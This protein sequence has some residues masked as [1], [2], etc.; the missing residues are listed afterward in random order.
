MITVLKR[1]CIVDFQ[2]KRFS[3]Y[4]VVLD[5]VLMDAFDDL[6]NPP[7][8]VLSVVQNRWLSTGLKETAIATAVWSILKAKRRL[9]KV[10][11]N[12]STINFKFSFGR[13]DFTNR[14]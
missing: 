9:L 4:D 12:T 8:S 14:L 13:W 10:C 11:V 3:L 7:S 6:C 5:W 2:V 1:F